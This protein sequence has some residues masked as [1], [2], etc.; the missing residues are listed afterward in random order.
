M[1]PI[2]AARIYHSPTHNVGLR[3]GQRL[4]PWAVAEGDL[5]SVMQGL[6]TSDAA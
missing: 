3:C 5:R 4:R 1:P 2:N 6:A